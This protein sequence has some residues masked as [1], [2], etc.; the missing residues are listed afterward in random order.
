MMDLDY[1]YLTAFDTKYS[2]PPSFLA[3]LVLW[4]FYIQ[5]VG[6]SI[7]IWKEIDILSLYLTYPDLIFLWLYTDKLLYVYR[8]ILSKKYK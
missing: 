2:T 3:S 5:I 7:H 1:F 6:F 8:Y 4:L